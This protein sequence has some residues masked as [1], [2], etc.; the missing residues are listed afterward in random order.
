MRGPRE[1]LFMRRKIRERTRKGTKVSGI[2]HRTSHDQLRFF[3][4]PDPERRRRAEIGESPSPRWIADIAVIG[5]S[6][7]LGHSARSEEICFLKSERTADSSRKSARNDKRERDFRKK[8]IL[9]RFRA[10]PRDS[11]D[12][13]RVFWPAGDSCRL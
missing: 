10:I 2:L 7:S 12:L 1:Q 4:N 13:P 5:T 11:G 3:C 6:P 8:P 9:L